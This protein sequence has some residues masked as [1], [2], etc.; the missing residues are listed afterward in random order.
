MA[1]DVFKKA[2]SPLTRIIWT[3]GGEN[4]SWGAK[5]FLHSRC[6][7]EPQQ[8]FQPILRRALAFAPR[9]WWA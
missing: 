8:L 3:H 2:R 4:R 1:V 7:R 9:V 6:Q 5:Y